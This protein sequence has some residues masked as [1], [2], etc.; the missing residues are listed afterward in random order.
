MEHI[1]DVYQ[2]AWQ[3]SKEFAIFKPWEYSVEIPTSD[4]HEKSPRKYY[5]QKMFHEYMDLLHEQASNDTS[6][7]FKRRL[8]RRSSLT[9]KRKF[10]SGARWK[11]VETRD[12]QIS[13]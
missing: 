4:E 6:S 1:D 3:L 7:K 11:L 12:N 8:Y 5:Y 2:N 10:P 13:F 9:F